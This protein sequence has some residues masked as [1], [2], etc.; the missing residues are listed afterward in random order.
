[1]RHIITIFLLLGSAIYLYPLSP[2]T[3]EYAQ[4][5]DWILNNQDASQEEII[6]F[7]DYYIPLSPSIEF[8][9]NILISIINSYATDKIPYTVYLLF[10]QIASLKFDFHTA[11]LMYYTTYTQTNN[12]LYL[13][14]SAIQEFE[15]GNIELAS[16]YLDNIFSNTSVNSDIAVSSYILKTELLLLQETPEI[17]FTFLENAQYQVEK[18]FITSSFLYQLYRIATISNKDNVA[19]LTHQSLVENFPNSLEAQLIDNNTV[20]PLP[21]PSL[22]F[23]GITI[24]NDQPA[25][26]SNINFPTRKILFS[27]AP[28]VGYQVGAFSN[29]QNARISLEYYQELWQ[30]RQIQSPLPILAQKN[31]EKGKFY[32]V[33]FPLDTNEIIQQKQTLVLKDKGIEGFVIKNN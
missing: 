20:S 33:I 13:L 31:T 17:A 25:N 32:Q 24:S 12:P 1:M 2:S 5:N 15:L 3:N 11:S 9:Y 7:L 21:L 14:Q 8:T 29:L 30:E 10:A 18:Q 4:L 19:F 27:H 22:L 23:N 26:T 28:D 6:T 16:S